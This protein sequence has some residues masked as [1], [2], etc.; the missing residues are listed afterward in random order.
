[1]TKK[2]VSE[3]VNLCD[4]CGEPLSKHNVGEKIMHSACKKLRKKEIWTDK[5]VR[6]KVKKWKKD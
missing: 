5:S 2:V 4:F 6:Y 1:M 3:E